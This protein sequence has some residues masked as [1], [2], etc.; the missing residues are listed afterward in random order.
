VSGWLALACWAAAAGG[1]TATDSL[2]QRLALR[3]AAP[4]AVVAAVTARLGPRLAG[5][6]VALDVGSAPEVNIER[7]LALPPD[8]TPDAPLAR[9]WVDAQDV[10]RAVLLL[11]PRRADRVLVRTV[12]LTLGLDEAG[13]AQVT[14]IIERSVASLLASEPI[15]VPHAEARAALAAAP[16]AGSVP[17]GAL[18]V[19][20]Q[21]ALQV[22]VFGGVGSWSSAALLAPRIGLDLWLDWITGDGRLGVA[23]SAAVDPAFHSTDPGGDLLVRAVAVHAWLTAGRRL[24]ALGVGRLALGPALLV[25]HVAPALTAASP[26]AT[27]TQAARTDVDPMLGLVAR[28]DF[29]LGGAGVFLAATLD[30]VPIRA[31]YTAMFD[32]TDRQLF[33]PWPLRPGVVLGASLG[34][35]RPRAR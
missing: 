9:G 24:G 16:P 28:W 20:K 5:L 1:P 11:V 8:D 2:P 21:T 29:P 13:L 12:P 10:D 23:A 14:F 15:G 35:E 6:G 7:I 34:S 31:S 18:G 33:S 30:Y 26:A 17:D 4:P 32:G 3:I 19:E 22:G 25:T 27:I